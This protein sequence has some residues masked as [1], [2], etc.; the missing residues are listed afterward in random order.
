M[1]LSRPSPPTLHPA[2]PPQHLHCRPDTRTQPSATVSGPLARGSPG[3]RRRV[4]LASCVCPAPGMQKVLDKHSLLAGGAPVCPSSLAPSSSP[5]PSRVVCILTTTESFTTQSAEP[6]LSY[7]ENTCRAETTSQ[8]PCPHPQGVLHLCSLDGRT[9]ASGC[10]SQ[11]APL[12]TFPARLSHLP[13]DFRGLL[14]IADTRSE[15][16]RHLQGTEGRSEASSRWKMALGGGVAHSRSP[17]ASQTSLKQAGG[18]FK[19]TDSLQV[20]DQPIFPSK[21][22]L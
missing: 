18:E 17:G 13:A 14:W 11:R 21:H 15:G 3:G 8:A 6:E 4:C 12:P 22:H 9:N 10:E 16:Q 1:L 7:Q 20:R 19:G 5:A 2:P